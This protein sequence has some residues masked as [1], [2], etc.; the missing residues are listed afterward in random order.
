M[1]EIISKT[2]KI[3]KPSTGI[4][5]FISDFR[6]LKEVVPQDKVND[7]IAEEDSC[8]FTVEG[9]GKAGLKIVEK[10]PPKLIKMTNNGSLPVDFNLWLQLKEV[11]NNDT[12]IRITVRA[13][14]NMMM[15]MMVGKKLQEGADALI[16][17]ICAYF[18][19]KEDI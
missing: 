11:E 17:Y 19:K 9:L 14:L 6:N 16:D 2:G 1:T 8:E 10:E 12:R 3:E 13:E 7:F 15:K 18:N 5:N 4:Y